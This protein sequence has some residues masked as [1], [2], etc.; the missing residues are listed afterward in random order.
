[1]VENVINIIIP[2]AIIEYKYFQFLFIAKYNIK[3]TKA[4]KDNIVS[5]KKITVNKE[6]IKNI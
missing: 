6:K 4:R 3:E 2:I 5:T 1:M